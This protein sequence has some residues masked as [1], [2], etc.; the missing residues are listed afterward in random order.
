MSIIYSILK[1][2][3]FLVMARKKT[4]FLS[5]FMVFVFIFIGFSALAVE[6]TDI[7]NHWAQDYILSLLNQDVMK[8]YSDGTFKPNQAITRGEFAVALAKQMSLI[9]DKNTKFQDL[10]GYLEYDYINALVS[11]NIINGYPDGT[12][13]P[14]KP[15]TRAE[16]ISI[17]IKSLGIN[18]NQVTINL[19]NYEPFQ[20]IS[21]NHWALNHIKL[22]QKLN[23]IQGDGQEHFYPN[24]KTSRAESAKVLV[25]MAELAS[26]T[27][28]ITDVY[29][30]SQ[31]VSINFLNGTREVLTY[32]NSTLV[33][34]N[35]RLVGIQD[36]LKTDKVFVITENN[37][38]VKYIKAYGMVTQEDLST[39]ISSLTNGFIEPAEV[40]DL[41]SG[42]ISFLKPKI[43]V[44]VRDQLMNQGLTTKEVNALLSTDWDQLEGLSRNRLSEAIAIQT[45]LPLDITRSMLQGD[46]ENI[47]SYAQIEIIQRLVQE[48][49]NSDL[50]S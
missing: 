50:L 17:M 19:D 23:L 46:W 3:G 11:K 37:S 10:E 22:A 26:N 27:G 35:N 30:T 25:K 44:A 38:N 29:P 47:K 12:F 31:K 33:G 14:D 5:A 36:I 24:Q 18:S 16:M 13:Q 40:K 28:Y 32:N 42:N 7:S 9:P 4:V 6:P 20:D 1:E 2:R 8:T 21:E 49:L 45:G 15:I 34:R 48:V 41:S 43:Q 39:E